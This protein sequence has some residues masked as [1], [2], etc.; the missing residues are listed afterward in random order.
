MIYGVAM[1]SVYEEAIRRKRES[2]LKLTEIEK[3]M[4]REAAWD[5]EFRRGTIHFL[6]FISIAMPLMFW[7]LV[8]LQ[9]KYIA[10]DYNAMTSTYGY[11]E[12]AG[13]NKTEITEVGGIQ[14]DIDWEKQNKP[15]GEVTIG[16]I[17]KYYTSGGSKNIEIPLKIKIKDPISAGTIKLQFARFAPDK[18][19][20][21]KY[22]KYDKYQKYKHLRTF[23]KTRGEIAEVTNIVPGKGGV[24]AEIFEKNSSLPLSKPTKF[25]NRELEAILKIS[26]PEKSELYKKLNSKTKLYRLNTSDPNFMRQLQIVFEPVFTVKDGKIS[27]VQELRE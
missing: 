3:F 14:A 20:I 9:P 1:N 7:F 8:H 21:Q 2:G 18:G 24:K 6:I 10:D 11:L 5:K 13:H 4:E 22:T 16:E 19:S 26:V 12:Q 25:E 23:E 15:Y 27:G 17:G